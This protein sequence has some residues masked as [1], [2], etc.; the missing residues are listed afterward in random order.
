MP[1]ISRRSRRSPPWL[2]F[3]D[4]L[5][6]AF[7]LVTLVIGLMM[8]A[9]GKNR[10]PPVIDLV[11]SKSYSFRL[12]SYQPSVAFRDMIRGELA[13][14]ILGLLKS[15]PGISSV[16]IIG[17]TDGVP[18]GSGASNLDTANINADLEASGVKQI[19]QA[20]SNVDLGLLRALYVKSILENSISARCHSVGGARLECRPLKYRV[21]SAGSLIS[22]NGEI[23]PAN[24]KSD[25]SRRR[26][27][28]RFTR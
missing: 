27:E 21:Y 16:E 17:H 10:Q 4:L 28:I 1:Y 11:E 13:I 25:P 12:G 2:T 19:Y 6:N 8:L 20:G 15:Y 7:F 26:I 5:G 22:G 23:S 14:R 24:G 9:T 18:N 3:S